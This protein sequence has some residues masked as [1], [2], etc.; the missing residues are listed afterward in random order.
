M[1][2]LHG[3]QRGSGIAR[4]A[5]RLR[6][7]MAD[8]A[9]AQHH[10]PHLCSGQRFRQQRLEAPLQQRRERR[11]G[12]HL[13]MQHRLGREDDQRTIALQRLLAQRWNHCAEFEGCA[14][15]MF[16]C[17]HSSSMRLR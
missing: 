9:T 4:L 7:V 16:C 5:A 3:Q 17:A 1:Q 14:T 10:P 13:G 6:Q 12:A 2:L 15:R 8:L 11:L